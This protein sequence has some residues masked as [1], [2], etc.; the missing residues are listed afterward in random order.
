MRQRSQGNRHAEPF[1]REVAAAAA[2]VPRSASTPAAKPQ[3]RAASNHSVSKRQIRPLQLTDDKG[4]SVRKASVTA[5]PLC[6]SHA[7]KDSQSDWEVSR[8]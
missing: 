2:A 4:G 5:R 3:G 8:G 6:I 1:A 7:P